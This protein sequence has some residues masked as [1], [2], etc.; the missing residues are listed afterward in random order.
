MGWW[1]CGVMQGDTPLDMENDILNEMGLKYDERPTKELLEKNQ[2]KLSHAL[3]AVHYEEDRTVGY[4][5]LGVMMI[6][7]GAKFTKKLTS[8]IRKAFLDDT[9]MA[10]EGENSERGRVM[11]EMAEKVKSYKPGKTKMEHEPGLFETMAIKL[12][13]K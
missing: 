5:V 6:E 7:T 11:L 12:G 2:L 3:D 13:G 4:Q 10:E 8:R 9:W 1:G